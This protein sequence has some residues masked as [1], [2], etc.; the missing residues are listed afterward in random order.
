MA[1]GRNLR[2]SGVDYSLSCPCVATYNGTIENFSFN[3]SEFHYLTKVK[4]Y[5]DRLYP[6]ILGYSHQEWLT[7]E[8]RYDNISAW[9]FEIIQENDTEIVFIEGYS[10]GSKGRVFNIAE[11]TAILKYKLYLEGIKIVSI[12]PTAIKKFATAKGN[13]NKEAMY[14]AFQAENGI[15]LKEEF[16][17]NREAVASPLS[18]IVDAYYILKYGVN[19][20]G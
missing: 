3:N 12:A 2:V 9:A 20:N 1:R 4:K 16:Q 8:D 5:D 14:E 17:P 13:S 15:N 19:E 6:N 7:D 10:M 18:D 11:N